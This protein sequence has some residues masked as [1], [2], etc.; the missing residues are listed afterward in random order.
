MEQDYF[1]IGK[2]DL[3]MRIV[4]DYLY[5]TPSKESAARFL[6]QMLNGK[7]TS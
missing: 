3:L 4:D 6:D 5:I 2:D 1:Q 7:V